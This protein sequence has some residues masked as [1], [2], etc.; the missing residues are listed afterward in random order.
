MQATRNVK[1]KRR[2]GRAEIRG[3]YVTAIHV[4][5]YSNRLQTDSI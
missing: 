3:E 4:Q 2:E 5:A 1:E